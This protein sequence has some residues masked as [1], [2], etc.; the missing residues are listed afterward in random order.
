MEENPAD[1]SAIMIPPLDPT[2]IQLTEAECWAIVAAAVLMAFDVLTGL[3]GALV[4]HAFSST[5]M[6][7]GLGHKAMLVLVVALA[8]LVQGFAGHV[9]DLG[10]SVPLILPACVYI[11]LMEVASVLENVSLAYPELAET[12][13]FKLFNHEPDES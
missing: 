10:F 8:F 4:R 5:K 7:E 13:L 6:R 3:L 2:F 11:V 9:A 1:W 12:P